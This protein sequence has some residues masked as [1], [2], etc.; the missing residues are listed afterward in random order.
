MQCEGGMRFCWMPGCGADNDCVAVQ[1]NQV[2]HSK[3]GKRQARAAMCHPAPPFV[4]SADVSSQTPALPAHTANTS[5]CARPP[6]AR[7]EAVIQ[8]PR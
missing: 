6:S 3:R 8:R 5:S 1:P 2:A 4:T 7:P